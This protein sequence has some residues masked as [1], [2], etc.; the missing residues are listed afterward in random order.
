M[1]RRGLVVQERECFQLMTGSF[2]TDEAV[3]ARLSHREQSALDRSEV[4]V[5]ERILN[6]LTSELA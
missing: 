5:P 6:R 1:T 3:T 2:V 4:P